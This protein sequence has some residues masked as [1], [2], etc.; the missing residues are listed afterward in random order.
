MSSKT[1]YRRSSSF[2][3]GKNA[4]LPS[5]RRIAG[6]DDFARVPAAPANPLKRAKAASLVAAVRPG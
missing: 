6:I 4:W 3:G 1:S 2:I 5:R